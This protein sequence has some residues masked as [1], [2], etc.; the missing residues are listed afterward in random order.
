[1]FNDRSLELEVRGYLAGLPLN[2]PV[3]DVNDALL[4]TF[5]YFPHFRQYICPPW[6]VFK[7][8]KGIF[9]LAKKNQEKKNLIATQKEWRGFVNINLTESELEEFDRWKAQADWLGLLTEMVENGYSVTVKWDTYSRSFM[10]SL[11]YQYR[12]HTNTGLCIT[13][14]GL[15]IE[16]VL[17]MAIFKH[18]VYCEENW[19]QY[20]KSPTGMSRG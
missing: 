10:S 14:R 2:D 8:T 17:A 3:W 19:D 5:F 16:D 18:Y 20:F 1:M 9:T 11:K 6:E 7:S 15:D 4:C 13:S 12:G